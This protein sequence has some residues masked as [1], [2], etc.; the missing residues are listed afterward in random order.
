MS[1]GTRP[2]THY[3]YSSTLGYLARHGLILSLMLVLC[4]LLFSWLEL[5]AGTL[6]FGS[7][8]AFL[9]RTRYRQAELTS[10]ALLLGYGFGR[11]VTVPYGIISSVEDRPAGI[12]LPPRFL[13]RLS[14]FRWYLVLTPLP[15]PKCARQFVVPVASTAAFID[16]LKA[17]IE[18]VTLSEQHEQY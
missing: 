15:L 1:D 5:I 11:P 2:T 13:V 10:D 7:L 18:S 9:V 4:I 3:P 6:A 16:D 12:I 8:F 14:G 17:R